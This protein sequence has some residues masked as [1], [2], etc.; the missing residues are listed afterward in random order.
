MQSAASRSVRAIVGFAIL[1]EIAAVGRTAEID[2]ASPRIIISAQA[3]A[4]EKLMARELCR[5]LGRVTGKQSTIERDDAT[6]GD[7]SAIVLL[8]VAGNNRLAAEI[9]AKEKLASDQSALGADG[10]RWKATTC[11][12][13]PAVLIVAATPAGVMYGVYQLA[14]MTVSP[15]VATA[16]PGQRR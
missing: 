15:S 11:Q 14:F 13:K 5:C 4:M 3:S 2:L 1:A 7:A 6:G 10:F 9:E 8:D 12:G 16:S